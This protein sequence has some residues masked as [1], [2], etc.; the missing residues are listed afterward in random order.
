MKP[1]FNSRKKDTHERIVAAA[2]HA[3]RSHGY[4]GVSV[5]EVMKKAGYTHGGFYA[6]FKSRDALLVEAL[7]CA[8][9]DIAV[10]AARVAR[11]RAGTGASEFRCLVEAYLADQYLGTLENG[12]PIA[13]LAA[14]MPR[15]SLAVRDASMARVHQLIAAVRSTLPES[16]RAMASLIAG[17][18]VGTLQLARALGDTPQ[19]REV[20]SAARE[21]LL[22]LYDTSAPAH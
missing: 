2:A 22:Q 1:T 15:Q 21:S 18:L 9:Q 10:E 3:I 8:S 19:G 13:A 16:Y 6:H 17:S 7:N 5:A 12:C 4:A 11:L 20:L 14:E